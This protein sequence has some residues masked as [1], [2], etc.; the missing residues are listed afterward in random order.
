MP[1]NVNSLIATIEYLESLETEDQRAGLLLEM[2]AALEDSNMLMNDEQ[3]LH[4]IKYLVTLKNSGWLAE[5]LLNLNGI[6]SIDLPACET[7]LAFSLALVGNPKSEEFDLCFLNNKKYYDA[8]ISKIAK[9]PRDDTKRRLGKGGYKVVNSCLMLRMHDNIIKVSVGVRASVSLGKIS[10]QCDATKLAQLNASLKKAKTIDDVLAS[11]KII[12]TA[13]ED[14]VFLEI[15]RCYQEMKFTIIL[16]DS[17]N[18]DRLRIGIPFV[19][20]GKDDKN[21]IKVHIFDTLAAHKDLYSMIEDDAMF[22]LDIIESI[23]DQF[24]AGLANIHSKGILHRDFKPDNLL[25]DGDINSPR[26]KIIDWGL[27]VNVYKVR[28]QTKELVNL[29]GFSR[30]G[31]GYVDGRLLD[32]LTLEYI[33]HLMLRAKAHLKPI[34]NHELTL[35]TLNIEIQKKLPGA[36]K[37]EYLATIGTLKYIPPEIFDSIKDTYYANDND[38][39]DTLASE[40]VEMVDYTAF[41]EEPP[42]TH[43]THDIWAAGITI[44]E[45]CL[46][47]PPLLS[48]PNTIAFIESNEL[49]QKMLHPNPRLRCTSKELLY[50]RKARG[51]FVFP[52]EEEVEKLVEQYMQKI[53]DYDLEL[54]NRDVTNQQ[55]APLIFT[56]AEANAIPTSTI[57]AVNKRQKMSIGN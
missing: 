28:M 55:P 19:K 9:Y 37:L 11:F 27:A 41:L 18:V 54:V 48:K 7:S 8:T 31:Y 4:I 43:E 36:P 30:N 23:T 33:L 14:K 29:L 3:L 51:R 10:E 42:L 57:A 12:A 52:K 44:V 40:I 20:K 53:E 49:L 5:R 47:E 56:A 35:D 21:N 34:H 38:A 6:N 26:L 46:M 45:Y 39:T 24:I 22:D 13:I 15:I 32:N 16:N 25:L 2:Q 1:Y 17:S 50:L